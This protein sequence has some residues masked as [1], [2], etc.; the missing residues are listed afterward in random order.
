MY[1]PTWRPARRRSKVSPTMWSTSRIKKPFVSWRSVTIAAGLGIGSA[2]RACDELRADPRRAPSHW[3]RRL[4]S[5]GAS[6]VVLSD[7]EEAI[8]SLFAEWQ[9]A[10]QARDVDR[11][12]KFITDD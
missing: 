10:S 3:D 1:L 5:G 8:R 9:R 11:L 12:L 2:E 7:D 4:S 6:M